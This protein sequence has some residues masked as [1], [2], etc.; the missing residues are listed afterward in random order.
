[1]GPQSVPRSGLRNSL[2]ILRQRP[3]VT[4]VAVLTLALGIGANT[5]V[6]SV[7]DAMILR[8]LP[9]AESENLVVPLMSVRD[10]GFE[11]RSTAYPDLLDWRQ[12]EDLFEQAALFFNN[13]YDLTNGGEPEKLTALV[14]TEDYFRLMRARPLAGRVLQS[15]DF[16]PGAEKVVVLSRNLWNRRFGNRQDILGETLLLSDV[17]HTV[18]GI[19][20][21]KATFPSSSEIW[22]PFDV[23]YPMREDLR[24]RDNFSGRSLLRL[25]PGVTLE[26]A[27]I[28]VASLAERVA[29]EEPAKRGKIEIRLVN[30]KEDL[31]GADSRLVLGLVFASVFL[32]LMIA[33][34]NVANL[35]LVR[36]VERSREMALR[37]ALGAGRG[38]L[39]R[40][41]LSESFM[42]T[43]LSAFAGILL[44]EWTIQFL[45]ARAP[46][47]IPGLE[48]LSL[49]GTVLGFAVAV[50]SLTALF[51]GLLPALQITRSRISDSLREAGAASASTGHRGR[52]LRNGLVITELALSLILLVTAGLMIRSLGQIGQRG[53]GIAIKSRLSFAVNPPRARYPEKVLR[54]TF[55]E[56]LVERLRA[57]PQVRR[58][59]A[60][61]SLPLGAGGSTVNR[62]HLIENHPEPP[63]GP[64]HSAAWNV[65]APDYFRTIGIS[66][67]RGRSFTN[68]DNADAPPVIIINQTLAE[69][70]FPDQNPIGQRIR[71]WRDENLLREIVGV[72]SSVRYDGM[73]EAL[74]PMVYVPYQQVGWPNLQKVVLHT[75]GDPVHLAA[76]IRSEVWNQDDKLPVTQILTLEE[77]A[78]AS[79]T[80]ERYLT[81]VLSGF[82]SLALILAALGLYGVVSYSISQRTREI[83]IRMALGAQVGDVQRLVM[84]QGLILALVGSGVGLLVVLSLS[85]VL[86]GLL[87][88]V[89]ATDPTTYI[90]VTGLLMAVTLLAT[91]GPAWR[92]A[93]VAPLEALRHE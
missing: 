25:K 39:I 53:A 87:I 58:V 4:A 15:V 2:A 8:P 79:V 19:C 34:F 73:A 84:R 45:R 52:R 46:A 82:S 80:R 69:S 62:V 56:D 28:R 5:A 85:R 12:Q 31:V 29:R 41:L 61:A 26:E 76:A 48:Q 51:F 18:I 23:G 55:F 47:E 20:D 90:G 81:W 9:Y 86:S 66:L 22:L 72:V 77:I 21:A 35:L 67:I 40:L 13:R 91:L 43:L 16:E 7:I 54:D 92:A 88:E 10:T 44:A 6:F 71:S 42:L 63:D 3:G 17:P 30:F 70:M 11:Y 65:V 33:C 75:M 14:V 36:A 38:H 83:G 89:S 64:E 78:A 74:R 1:M 68:S 59:S 49:N 57:L 27:D 93:R 24:R 60:A 37:V 32:V 50:S